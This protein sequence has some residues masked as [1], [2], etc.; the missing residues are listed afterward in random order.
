MDG[1]GEVGLVALTLVG[2]GRMALKR[3]IDDG[4]GYGLDLEE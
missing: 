1:G 3:C 2:L 4:A